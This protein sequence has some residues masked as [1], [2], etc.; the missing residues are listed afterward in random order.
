[1]GSLSSHS[2][3]AAMFI[4][5]SGL[6]GAAQLWK[7]KASSEHKFFFWLAMQDRCWTN[8]RRQRHGISN[9]ATYTLCQQQIKSMDHLIVTCVFSREVWFTMLQKCGWQD[10]SLAANDALVHWCIRSRETVTMQRRA[11]FDSLVLLVARAIWMEWSRTREFLWA[12][13][14]G[15]AS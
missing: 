3:Y 13:P 2:T 1:L 15:R 9:E 8:D 11:T 4:G 14:V 6:Q 12:P 7:T 5:Q 10:L